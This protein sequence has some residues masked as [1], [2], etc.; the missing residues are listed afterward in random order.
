MLFKNYLYVNEELLE[1]LAKQLEIEIS[2]DVTKIK[3]TSKK[4][5]VSLSN[6]S[7]GKESINTDTENFKNDKFDLLRIFEK[8]ILDDETGI[9]D[10][11]FEEADHIFSGQLIQFTA[12]IM[13]PKGGKENIE[14]INSIR[15]SPILSDLLRNSVDESNNNNQKLLD[16]MLKESSS[17]PVYFSNDGNYIVV[18]NIN[19]NQLEVTYEDFQELYDEEVKAIVLVD[20]KYT[21]QQEVVLM[22][23]M[24]D[25]LKIGRDLRRTMAKTEQEKYIIKEKGPAMK[26]E[27]LAIYN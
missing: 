5:A 17:I 7:G 12:K 10:F 16:L 25:V 14:L 15:Q 23:V 8:K 9:I 18:S 26:G 20:R 24:K 4:A 13:Q 11:D 6:L 19:I 22:D 21:E 27:I 3:Q 2:Y 1:K